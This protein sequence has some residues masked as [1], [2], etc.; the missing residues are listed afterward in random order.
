M[1]APHNTT[2]NNVFRVHCGALSIPVRGWG[3]L[4]VYAVG[5]DVSIIHRVCLCWWDR[6]APDPRFRGAIERV[7][8][9]K[10]Q[11]SLAIQS[12]QTC[13]SLQRRLLMWI[14]FAVSVCGVHEAH[15]CGCSLSSL[16]SDG[17]S[18]GSY[19]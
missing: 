18:F 1:P 12:Q 7:N 9:P 5:L 8:S 13:C 6:V 10:I 3:R 19:S 4:P 2:D 14:A 15:A 16:S 11:F 17:F